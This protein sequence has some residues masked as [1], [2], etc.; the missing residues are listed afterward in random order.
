LYRAAL[1]RLPGEDEAR[2]CNELLHARN[3]NVVATL[4]DIWWAVLNSGE[5][6]LVH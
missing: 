1:G 5:F 6:I 4:E 3:G 2:V